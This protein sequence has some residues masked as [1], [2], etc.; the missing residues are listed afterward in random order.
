MQTKYTQTHEGC[1]PPAW[2]IRDIDYQAVGFGFWAVLQDAL[3]IRSL[4]LVVLAAAS[5]RQLIIYVIT[6]IPF[7]I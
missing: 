6:S 5:V 1:C 7:E 4:H 3:W 2:S